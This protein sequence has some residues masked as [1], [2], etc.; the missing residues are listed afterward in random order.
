MKKWTFNTITYN[1]FTMSLLFSIV[2]TT[3]AYA[4]E[5][6]LNEL[7]EIAL[8][9]SERIK[10]SEEELYISET[11]KK[12]AVA[13]FLP[14]VTAYGQYYRY[15]TDKY[16]GF[17]YLIQPERTLLGGVK[18]EETISLGGAQFSRLDISKRMIEKSGFE[19]YSTKETF[20]FDVASWYFNVLKAKTAVTLAENSAER[21]RSYKNSAETKLKAGEITKTALY[22]A[23]AELSGA[24]AELLK[25]Q[26]DLSVKTSALAR[27]IG[28][29][30]E[31]ALADYAVARKINEAEIETILSACKTTET[32][33]LVDAAMAERAEVK[34]AMSAL[35]M[36]KKQISYAKSAFLP[37][38]TLE[39][40]YQKRD[41]SPPTTDNMPPETIY[42]AVKLSFPVFEGGLRYAEVSE[43]VH[44]K[45]QSELALL[46]LK[47]SLEN[48]VEASYYT[49]LTLK[50]T[51][52]YIRDQLDYASEN[53]IA[54]SRQ[55]NEGLATS[56]DVIDANNLLTLSE[57]QY[58]DAYYDLSLS[59][60]KLKRSVG[61]F[62]KSISTKKEKNG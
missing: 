18:L 9:N 59:T 13:A 20:L 60:L 28:I 21:L 35:E 51:F 46:D 56:L 31:F 14:N 55:F 15:S 45:N 58:F 47:K 8:K 43:A 49:F 7:Y 40:L 50:K 33:C 36:T 62:L 54:V 6:S 16:N 2:L 5:Y 10:I 32:A 22:R 12:K 17:N 24:M 39:G 25:A 23:K 19:L 4:H 38:L 37:S 29:S 53:Y 34:A 11:G 57:K 1:L 44:K 52:T 26:N 3:A 41:D 61:L 48:D 42:G 30:G 27:N